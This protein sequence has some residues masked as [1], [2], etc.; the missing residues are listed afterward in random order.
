MKS[1]N[2]TRHALL[3]IVAPARGRGL[4][5]KHYNCATKKDRRPRKG[6]WIEIYTIIVNK[7]LS[8][9]APARGR[10]LKSCAAC[11]AQHRRLVAP[12][13]GRGLK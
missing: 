13:R 1:A 12:A 9:V 7:D 3:S 6:A 4:K 10:G 8:E 5:L 2:H 11:A